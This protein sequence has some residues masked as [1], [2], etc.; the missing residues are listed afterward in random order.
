MMKYVIF[1]SYLSL[2]YATDYLSKQQRVYQNSDPKPLKI[3][4]S[5]RQ[6]KHLIY[7][8]KSGYFACV[9]KRN[10]EDCKEKEK[11][12]ISRNHLVHECRFFKS[13]KDDKTC[14]QKQ[15]YF[16]AKQSPKKI[17]EICSISK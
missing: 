15:S 7:D 2:C 5:Y 16:M 14:E 6:G 9:W 4:K 1:L 13:F 8:C 10:L 17:N 3:S 11:Y 12:A